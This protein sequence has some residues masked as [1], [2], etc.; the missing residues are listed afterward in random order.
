[1][2]DEVKQ[3]ADYTRYAAEIDLYEKDFGTWNE[4]GKKILK[5]YK[6][7]RPNQKR[8]NI[9]WSN[10]ETLKPALYARDPQPVAERR[11]K[12]SDP[13]GRV[14]SE[15]LERCVSYTLDCQNFGYKMRS[16]VSDRLLPGRG[17][18][19]TRY[20]PTI[21]ALQISEDPDDEELAY[22]EAIPDYVYWED[23][24]HNSAR[25]W[26]EV[27]VVWRR[28]YL[29]REQLVKRFGKEGET[30]SLDYSPKNI[31]DEKYGEALK[32]ACIYEGV[33]RERG[34]W[35]WLS[36]SSKKVLDVKDAPL[37]LTGGFPCVRPLYA[38]IS[39]DSLI[40]VPDYA[41]YQTQAQELENLTRRIDKI[42]KAL[43]VVGV[44]D[45]SASELSR[46]LNEGYENKMV[47]VD[48]WA[49][50]AEKGGIEGAID[51]LPIKDIAE[52]LIALYEAREKSKA[53]LYE[54][55]GIADII[56]G[57]SDPNET[58]KAQQI[59]GRFAVLRI[60]DSQAE[61]Q[62]F[63]RDV[64][65][66]IAE[67]IAENFDLETIKQISGVKLLTQV[68]KEQAEKAQAQYQQQAQ[69]A[70]Q[71]Q[72]PPPPPPFG[73]EI[74]EL[75][76]E[77][78]W[79]EV[80]ALL[81]SQVLREFRI[82][83]ET[84]STIRTDEEADRAE[85]TEFLTAAGGY[86]KSAMEA[87]QVA[88]E[89]KELMAEL[90]MFGVRGHRSA[91]QLEPAFEKAMKE[92]QKPKQ[93]QPDPEMAKLQAEQQMKEKELQ[94]EGQFRQQ[95]MQA[96]GQMRQQELAAEVQAENAKQEAQNQQNQQ[97]QIM[98][99]RRAQLEHE[100]E[101]SMERYRT[102][103]EIRAKKE[104]AVIDANAKVQ[105]AKVQAANRPKPQ[106]K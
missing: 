99:D 50:F 57:N 18:V 68:E 60:S 12:D 61:V 36:K 26:D 54:I 106:G 7:S 28:V 24:G 1:M 42:Q 88:P 89:L 74:A 62:R 51:F 33:D 14:S 63:A 105:A 94:Q 39:T 76:T 97:E 6:D 11:F 87:A 15:V 13:V 5:I 98:A 92:M 95:E 34:K 56:R 86:L 22:E 53:D 93:P 44:Y 30:V 64:V 27:W 77:P 48:N 20:K 90:L 31:N 17:T 37:K 85:R 43:K 78:T 103:E 83:I 73:E 40:P 101:L 21:N 65:R 9:L 2:K 23:F 80:H 91:R 19:W 8:F 3:D 81:S 10:V 35:F 100:R 29:T 49:A 52:V 82:D 46:V 59:K 102:D 25:T 75:L 47:P 84:D 104:I 55:T 41:Q 45:T 16:V 79:E 32:K 96:E 4:R 67:I 38:T 66:L 70:Q 72:Q 71:A 69:M 58:A